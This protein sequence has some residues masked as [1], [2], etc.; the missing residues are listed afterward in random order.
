MKEIG[1]SGFGVCWED[2]G[3]KCQKK[4]NNNSNLYIFINIQFC[5]KMSMIAAVPCITE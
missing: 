3:H 1:I 5:N 4:N 2:S